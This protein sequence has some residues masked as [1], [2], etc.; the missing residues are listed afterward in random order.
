MR[1]PS[2]L[3]VQTSPALRPPSRATPADRDRRALSC[4][5]HPEA[6]DHRFVNRSREF[7]D[8][9][10]SSEQEHLGQQRADRE[11]LVERG[12][13]DAQHRDNG[14]EGGCRCGGQLLAPAAREVGNCRGDGNQLRAGYG[15]VGVA[16]RAG[17]GRFGRMSDGREISLRVGGRRGRFT[18]EG[19]DKT[20]GLLFVPIVSR[21]CPERFVGGAD[22]EL[23][24]ERSDQAAVLTT[25]VYSFVMRVYPQNSPAGCATASFHRVF[26]RITIF[27]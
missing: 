10:N 24:V 16:S 27:G 23:W 17:R 22:V 26:G 21:C 20:A 8:G 4:T 7:L 25:H 1:P 5:L 6:E 3:A 2:T 18:V 19:E 13:G 15:S 9:A 14:F 12:D 11:Q